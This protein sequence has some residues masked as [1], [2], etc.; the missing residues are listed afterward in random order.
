MMSYEER[1]AQANIIYQNGLNRVKNTP[2]P[3]GQKF[4]VGARVRIADNLGKYMSHFPSGKLATVEYTYAHAYGGN[5]VKSYSLLIDGMGSHAW[6]E[7]WQ[8]EHAEQ[9]LHLT[10][11]AVGGLAFLAG[12][13]V[14]WLW[15][16]R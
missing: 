3:K 6:Y 15:L 11:I 1:E 10:A 16:V 7:E 8:L 13:G 2:A 12:F 4:P 5:D 9:R 14:C